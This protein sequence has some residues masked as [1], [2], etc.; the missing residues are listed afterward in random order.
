MTEYVLRAG[1]KTMLGFLLLSS[2]AN[3]FIDCKVV[4]FP[5][6]SWVICGA[7]L[8]RYLIFAL[9]LTLIMNIRWEASLMF[10]VLDSVA[11]PEGV[12]GFHSNPVPHPRF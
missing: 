10:Y 8:Y 1:E 2:Y 7:W 5:L 6:V 11:G 4:T 3:I 12:Q 9:L